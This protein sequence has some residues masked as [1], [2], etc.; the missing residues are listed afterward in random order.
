VKL[1]Y[2]FIKPYTAPKEYHHWEYRPAEIKAPDYLKI[3]KKYFKRT[4]YTTEPSRKSADWD[5]TKEEYEANQPAT[6]QNLQ[7]DIP[8][9]D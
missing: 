4:Y 8:K 6:D 5:I 1:E 9:T 7:P 3:D 2:N